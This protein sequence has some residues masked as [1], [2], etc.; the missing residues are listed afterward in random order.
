MSNY[1]HERCSRPVTI[2]GW[3][4]EDAKEYQIRSVRMAIRMSRAPTEGRAR[5][6][7]LR[8]AAFSAAQFSLRNLAIVR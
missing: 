3:L 8:F 1:V 2:S 5:T 6:T 7:K 4:G